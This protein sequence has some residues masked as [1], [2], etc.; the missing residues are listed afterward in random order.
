M[1]VLNE[2]NRHDVTVNVGDIDATSE[3]V[4]FHAFKKIMIRAAAI[5]LNIAHAGGSAS[6]N[7]Q[8][9]LINRDA[10][11]ADTNVGAQVTTEGTCLL[12]TSPSPRD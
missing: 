9:R 2:D 11:G 4:V 6:N 12:Y 1:S 8:L 10:D 7:N 5:V 3:T